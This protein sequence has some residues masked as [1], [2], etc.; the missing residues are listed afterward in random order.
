MSR[1][2]AR[3]DANHGE[4]VAEF[5]RLGCAVESLAGM[6]KGVPDLLVCMHG[7]NELVEVKTE[8]GKLTEDQVKWFAK[9]P[10]PVHVVRSTEDVAQLVRWAELMSQGRKHE[11]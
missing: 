8:K 5:R 4:I 3:V 1:R 6:G 9:W 7:R 10:A 11:S 2:A